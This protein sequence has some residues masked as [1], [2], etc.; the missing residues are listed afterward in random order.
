LWKDGDPSSARGYVSDSSRVTMGSTASVAATE[1]VSVAKIYSVDRL[2][3]P[4]RRPSRTIN[5]LPHQRHPLP[6][7]ENIFERSGGQTS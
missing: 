2:V 4:R 6:C 7:Q 5:L 3:P 1:P